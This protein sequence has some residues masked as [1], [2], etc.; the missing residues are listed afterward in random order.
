MRARYLLGCDGAHSPVRRML[1]VPLVD[2]RYDEPW[3]AV[4]GL[5]AGRRAAL[6]PGPP[7]TA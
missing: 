5:V 2:K 1:A 3:L 4:A 7:R 6:R